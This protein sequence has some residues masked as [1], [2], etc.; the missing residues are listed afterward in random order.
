MRAEHFP[1]SLRTLS[2]PFRLAL[3]YI[4]WSWC[5]LTFSVSLIHIQPASFE[6]IFCPQTP[7][8]LSLSTGYWADYHHFGLSWCPNES[9][10]VFTWGKKKQTNRKTR[11]VSSTSCYH[12]CFFRTLRFFKYFFGQKDVHFLRSFS[13]WEGSC[14]LKLWTNH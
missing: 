8:V 6:H 3:S 7:N 13:P 9:P 11:L 4:S 10:L 1:K 14:E 12:F 2:G 5:C